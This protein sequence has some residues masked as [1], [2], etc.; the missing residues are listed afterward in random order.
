VAEGRG[1]VG[2]VPLA[3]FDQHHPVC[4]SF[5]GFANSFLIAHHPSSAEE[6]ISSLF[7]VL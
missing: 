4:A 1:G 2:Q 7:P 5:G 6:G 3:E